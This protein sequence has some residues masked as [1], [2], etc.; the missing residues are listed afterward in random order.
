MVLRKMEIRV[1]VLSTS[2]AI[3]QIECSVLLALQKWNLRWLDSPLLAG[4]GG[5]MLDE[6]CLTLSPSP[7][8]EGPTQPHGVGVLE[9]PH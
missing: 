6:C 4:S 3:V 8:L 9:G 7:S 2:W 5:R 1:L